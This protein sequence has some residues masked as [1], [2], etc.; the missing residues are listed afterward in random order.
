[1]EQCPLLS[2]P[3]AFSHFLHDPQ[4]NR[5]LLVMIPRWV[6]LCAFQDCVGLPTNSPV[7]LGVSPAATTPTGFYCQRFCGFISPHWNPGLQSQSRS[8]VVP[9]GLSACKCGT[10]HQPPPCP[11]FQP[12]SRQ[13]IAPPW[14]PISTPPTHLDECFFFNS[15]VVGLPYSL[16]F[17]QFWLFFAFKFSVVLFLVVQGGKV[18]L[19]MP[20]SWP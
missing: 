10:G 5:A 16:I 11:I 2:S 4:A 3:P 6:G 8:P 1:M 19:P 20:A 12:L 7:R 17:W 18:Y 13:E 9:P 15:L 14:L